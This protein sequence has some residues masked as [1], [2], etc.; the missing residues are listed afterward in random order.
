MPR[1]STLTCACCVAIVALTARDASA[2]DKPTVKLTEEQITLNNRAVKSMAQQPPR[3]D[4]AVRL[5]QAALVVGEKGDLLYLTLGR[6]YQLQKKCKQAQTE[7]ERALAAPG[8]EDI[9]KTYVSEQISIYQKELMASC[10]GTLTIMCKPDDLKL[11]LPGHELVCQQPLSLPAGTYGVS[12]THPRTGASTSTQITVESMKTTTTTFT[13]TGPPTQTPDPDTSTPVVVPTTPPAPSSSGLALSGVVGGLAGWCITRVSSETGPGADATNGALC[14]GL[15]ADLRAGFILSESLTLA[16]VVAAQGVMANSVTDNGREPVVLR[17]VDASAGAQAW[18]WSERIGV[19]FAGSLRARSATVDDTDAGAARALSLG[20]GLMF[21][22][23][24]VVPSLD[25]LILSARWM[26]L[27]DSGLSLGARVEY[28][29]LAVWVSYDRWESE[30]DRA[31]FMHE[32]EQ[33]M[34]GV[35][36]HWGD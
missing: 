9:P 4:E 24:D 20:P 6:A 3:P 12:A 5:T 29:S 17:G 25:A 34:L 27:L 16:G 31:D 28:G 14:Y 19:E 1:Y 21:N 8:V 18:L 7:F 32:A 30:L 35:G 10:P 26:P 2:Q 13:L 15:H 33:A 22:A 23:A 36:F 11:S